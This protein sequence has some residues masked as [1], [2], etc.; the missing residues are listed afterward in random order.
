MDILDEVI[1]RTNIVIVCDQITNS[2]T[3][4]ELKQ[5]NRTDLTES[6]SKSK[7]KL[8]QSLV[9]FDEL[10]NELRLYKQQNSNLMLNI[11]MRD[12]KIE[13]LE[14]KVKEFIELL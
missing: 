1:A 3:E 5:P 13:E 9:I 4:I 14:L 12:K 8:I 11:Q 6:M 10:R 7:N 2:I